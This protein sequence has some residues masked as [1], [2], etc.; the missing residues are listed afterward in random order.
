MVTPGTFHVEDE[1]G[2][3]S[4]CFHKGTSIT[5]STQ[6]GLLYSPLPRG[7]GPSQLARLL[8]GNI[9]P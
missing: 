9:P 8:S 1:A 4:V 7:E 3:L 6:P 2:S 5:A